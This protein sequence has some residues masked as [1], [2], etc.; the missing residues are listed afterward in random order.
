MHHTHGEL[1]ITSNVP[2]EQMARH[3]ALLKKPLSGPL[4]FHF[5]PRDAVLGYRRTERSLDASALLE[6]LGDVSERARLHR[7][8]SVIP[9][10]RV[11]GSNAAACDAAEDARDEC[12]DEDTDMN[13][14]AQSGLG[15]D[16]DEDEFGEDDQCCDID[17]D[18]E[19]GT[20]ADEDVE[21]DDAE[22]DA[23]PDATEQV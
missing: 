22:F 23:G 8:T 19:D 2:V 15:M 20:D 9:K 3:P 10:I 5:Y 12:S 18:E 16:E 4:G 7:N 17:E 6:V 1:E 11:S 14:H 21:H 13:P